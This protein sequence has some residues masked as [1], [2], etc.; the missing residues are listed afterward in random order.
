LLTFLV[1]Y[2][3]FSFSLV[4]FVLVLVMA[5]L[6]LMRCMFYYGVLGRHCLGGL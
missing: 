6:Y 5:S 4:Y 1:S 3:E 2:N